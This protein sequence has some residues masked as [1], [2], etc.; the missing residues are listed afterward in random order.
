MW[1]EITKNVFLKT[2]LKVFIA[3]IWSWNIFILIFDRIQIYSRAQLNFSGPWE[4]FTKL[5]QYL[6]FLPTYALPNKTYLKKFI[7]PSLTLPGAPIHYLSLNPSPNLDT[8]KKFAA[9][10]FFLIPKIWQKKIRDC[11]SSV[12]P[13]FVLHFWKCWILGLGLILITRDSSPKQ[14]VFQIV[15][16]SIF[17]FFFW[18][19]Y[20][21][22]FYNPPFWSIRQMKLHAC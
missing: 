9:R 5:R 19:Q 16:K 2:C 21:F 13:H 17:F 1:T 4:N 18:F 3:F 7:S 10:W 12:V 22:L 6:I 20:I 15:T 14:L 8:F 11:L